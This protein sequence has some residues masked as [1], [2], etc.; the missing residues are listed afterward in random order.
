MQILITG[1]AGFVG[2][3]LA[4]TL[5]E[6]GHE[7]AG[8]DNLSA[9]S[10]SNLQPVLDRRHIAFEVADLG[11]IDAY[12]NALRELHSVRPITEVW[13]L[14]ANSDIAAGIA[15]PNIDFRNTFM[16]TYNTLLLMKELGIETIAFASSSAVYGDLSDRTLTEEMGPL[17]PISNYGAMKL[18]S[19]AVIS[20]A[21]QIHLKKAFL[22]RFPNVVGTPA[23]HGVILDFV[24]KL[25]ATPGEL[26]VLGDGTQRKSYLH[27][28]DVVDAMLFIRERARERLNCYNIGA[29]DDGVSVRSI[30]EMVV[31]RVSPGARISYGQGNRGWVGDVPRFSY[32]A[33]K[34]AELGWRPSLGSV[35]AIRKAIHEIAGMEPED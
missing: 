22:F 27:V 29:N 12:R 31:R 25:R 7:V 15:D 9:G 35:E 2:C 33:A 8:L 32:S 5:L 34:L 19:E 6:R 14:A 26:T 20:A 4:R 23:T 16:T 13:H 3:N 1:I 11:D 17:F 21:A 10:L 28:D 18:A 30:A 24:Q